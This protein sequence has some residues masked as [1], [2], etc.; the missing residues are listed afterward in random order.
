MRAA[1]VARLLLGT[2]CVAA[3]GPVLD[4]IGGADRD[5]QRTRTVTRVLG[6]RLVL[7]AAADLGFGART[8]RLDVAVD[9]SHAASMMPVAAI[10]PSHR[11]TALASA[12]LATSIA[13]LDLRAPRVLR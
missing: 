3:P 12:A 5:D 1:T 11:R 10:W 4:V 9:L 7:Q 6:G 8:R 2:A 13:V